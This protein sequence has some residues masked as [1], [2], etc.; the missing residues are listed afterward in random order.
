MDRPARMLVSFPAD[1]AIRLPPACR[2][3]SC[4][5]TLAARLNTFTLMDAPVASPTPR[6]AASASAAFSIQ[7]SLLAVTFRSSFSAVSVASV[8]TLVSAAD[9][10]TITFTTPAKEAPPVEPEPPVV[11]PSS[12]PSSGA[13][14]PVVIAMEAEAVPEIIWSD[15][16]EAMVRFLPALMVAL[17]PTAVLETDLSTIT[18]TVPPAAVWPR[19][20]G[21]L[22]E[23]SVRSSAV[24]LFTF[25][26]PAAVMVEPLPS[27]ASD[28]FFVTMT[29]TAPP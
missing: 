16:S 15:T 25:A 21:A 1:W 18:F 12:P 5:V 9:L 22:T 26:S 24:W 23:M 10:E 19:P 27:F 8:P 3:P 11:P 7:A 4:R 14:A 17:S 28:S 2:V 6:F 20:S 29:F 13:L